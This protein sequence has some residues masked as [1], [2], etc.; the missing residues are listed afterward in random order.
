M[1]QLTCSHCW[2][3]LTPC[4]TYS[5]TSS[6]MLE[7]G[8]TYMLPLLRPIGTPCIMYSSTSST[9]LGSS[10]RNDLGPCTAS[11]CPVSQ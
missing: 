7:K 10:C 5:S 8:L 3:I 1:G 11:A 6:L 9:M 2:P 4:I